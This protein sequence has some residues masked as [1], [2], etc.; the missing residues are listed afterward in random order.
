MSDLNWSWRTRKTN[1]KARD[2]KQR[3][4]ERHTLDNLQLMQKL[5]SEN[6]TILQNPTNILIAGVKAETN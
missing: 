3:A 6:L 1:V 4:V 2:G 5:K